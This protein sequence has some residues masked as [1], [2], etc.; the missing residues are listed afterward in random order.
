MVFNVF[1]KRSIL[2]EC[3]MPRA[4]IISICGTDEFCSPAYVVNADVKWTQQ[5]VNEI[6]AFFVYLRN[7][8]KLHTDKIMNVPFS[9]PQRIGPTVLHP[10]FSL[11][12][13]VLVRFDSFLQNSSH[14]SFITWFGIGLFIL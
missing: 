2:R 4:S 11:C 9:G 7:F 6:H 1:L 14:L 13:S 8:L 12:E 5:N 3:I 10:K